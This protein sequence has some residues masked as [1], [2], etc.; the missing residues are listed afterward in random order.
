METGGAR[1]LVAADGVGP[2][3]EVLAAEA[4][5]N[6]EIQKYVHPPG[7]EPGTLGH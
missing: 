4:M 1:V 6:S 2:E 5:Q 7:I 3:S